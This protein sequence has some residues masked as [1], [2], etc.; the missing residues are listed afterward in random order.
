MILLAVGAVCALGK[1]LPGACGGDIGL[2]ARQIYRRVDAIVWWA[3]VGCY[4]HPTSTPVAPLVWLLAAPVRL[5]GQLGRQA[6]AD[7][8]MIQG[9]FCGLP[10][11]TTAQY[12]LS[13]FAAIYL[14]YVLPCLFLKHEFTTLNYI[15]TY[16]LFSCFDIRVCEL[17]Y[18]GWC[19][20]QCGVRTSCQHH[21]SITAGVHQSE[22]L[23]I[24]YAGL[25]AEG[26][27]ELETQSETELENLRWTPW[28]PCHRASWRLVRP[29]RKV[30]VGV[31]TPDVVP[32]SDPALRSFYRSMR[33]V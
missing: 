31:L 8:H 5:I 33:N 16:V 23:L 28:T 18:V 4:S 27:R 1:L 32:V 14:A 15:H 19:N 17:H 20:V 13:L 9:C 10:V 2:T 30:H 11:Q 25:M 29:K 12:C 21:N 6:T 3:W 22:H 7:T 26:G 24:M